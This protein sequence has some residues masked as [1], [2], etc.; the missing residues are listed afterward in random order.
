M[1]AEI[2]TIGDELL[3]GQVV[4]T[5]SAWMAERLNEVGISLHQITSVHDN[6]EH[7]LTALDEAFSRADLV[8]T[9]GGLGPTK[10]D[11]TKHV[12]CEYFGTSL[13]EDSHVRA[14]V[15]ELY[16]DR[17]EALNRLTATQWLVPESATILPNRVGSAPIMVFENEVKGER[18]KVK[19][20][21]QNSKFLIALPGVPH[22]MKIAMTEQ[23]LPFIRLKVKGE[24][25]EAMD[26]VHKTILVH[27]IPESKLAILIE[28]WENALPSSIHLAYL[29]KDG[30]IRLRLSTYGEA[31]EDE[32]Q[33]HIDTLLPLI[34]DY[35]L[36]TEDISLEALAGRLLKQQGKT[37]ATAESCTGG[38]LAA[39]LNA[40]S[41]SSAYYMGSVVAYDNSIKEQVLG[42]QHDT[43]LQHGAVSEQ[44]VLRMAEGVRNLMHT[45][46]AIATSGIAG[47][48]GG[49]IDKP[50][51]TVWIAWA[52]PTGT[53]AKCFHF[54]AAR[55]REQITLRAVTESLVRLVK[56]LSTQSAAGC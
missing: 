9:T 27:G 53:D 52:T 23:V 16:K 49:T 14:H 6:R 50:V 43:L 35:L 10:D 12:M 26:I 56:T 36:A 38:R 2:I 18:L 34:S 20:E 45:D 54:G 40:Q 39:A 5:N 15:H 4:D 7:I 8:L 33:S 19:G 47:P 11:I 24:R 31:T 17:P 13:V 30:I 42:V 29:P 46:Y 22:E 41:G 25:R 32:L 28:D 55:E 51:G 44:T 37:I 48:T 21:G 1:R 3:I